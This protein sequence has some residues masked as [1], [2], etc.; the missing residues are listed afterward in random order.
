MGKSAIYFYRDQLEILKVSCM[1]DGFRH[2]SGTWNYEYKAR[3]RGHASS[4]SKFVPIHFFLT[5]FVLHSVAST[6]SVAR[7]DLRSLRTA[8]NSNR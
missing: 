1:D 6:I 4:G 8:F 3:I 5:R 2:E 7:L